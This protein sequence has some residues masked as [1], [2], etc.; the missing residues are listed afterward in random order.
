MARLLRIGCEV[1]VLMRSTPYA[2]AAA[3]LEEAV[4]I[5][6]QNGLLPR[7]RILEGDLSRQL[8]GLSIP[9]R[10]WLASRPLCIIHCAAS[11]RFQRVEESGEPFTTNVQG[12]EQLLTLCQK[13]DVQAFHYVSTA[14]VGSRV[15]SGLALESL[16]AP[17]AVGG[18][19]YEQSKIMAERSVAAA[20]HLG[21]KT[22]HRPSI[23]VGDSQSG[24]TSTYHGF[25]AP[26][27][28][29]FQLAKQFGFS[30]AATAWFRQQLGLQPKDNKNLVPVDWVAECIVQTVVNDISTAK[31]RDNALVLHWTNP[32]PAPCASM[33]AA[34]GSAIE[35]VSDE[36]FNATHQAQQAVTPPDFRQLMQVYESYFN[37]DPNFDNTQA[38]AA[39]P[40]LPCPPVDAALLGKLAD[41]AIAHNFGWPKSPPSAVPHAALRTA[42]RN[43][44]RELPQTVDE[45]DFRLELRL[46]GPGAPELL[47]FI[48]VAGRW[49]TL[50]SWEGMLAN[51]NRVS[52]T[53]LLTIPIDTL[54]D[55]FNGKTSLALA[56]E[57]G[58]C[59]M[60]GQLP[61]D[62]LAVVEHWMEDVRTRIVHA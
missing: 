44:L 58:C 23:I 15:Q 55:C 5:C 27:Q 28:I 59:I 47:R 10:Q 11:I 19:D 39:C 14:Y 24:F 18:N 7:P 56:F 41:F 53:T 36:P 38:Q 60:E 1:G 17:N 57:Q 2:S 46:L 8:L 40:Q 49:L 37:S 6:E 62:W 20:A 52:P 50:D 42:L 54:A 25:Y 32:H 12:T 43:G 30:S 3:R 51:S 31:E 13:L 22:I 26:L 34:I 4:A 35:R 16:P 21:K 33:Q 61:E 29:G 45:L 9:D 48:R